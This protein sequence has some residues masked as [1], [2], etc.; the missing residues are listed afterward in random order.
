[1]SHLYI[2]KLIKQRGVHHVET[3]NRHTLIIHY[4]LI[5]VY[6]GHVITKHLALVTRTYKCRFTCSAVFIR[7]IHVHY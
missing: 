4:Q 1:M 3:D 7:L 2:S 5:Q 6:W